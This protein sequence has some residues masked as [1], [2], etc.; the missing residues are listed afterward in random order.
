MK[1]LD[2]ANLLAGPARLNVLG[3]QYAAFMLRVNGLTAAGAAPTLAQFGLIRMT[4]DGRPC[5]SVSLATT[6]T[7]NAM[8]L[9]LV[10]SAIGAAGG[11]PITLS[12]MILSSRAGDGNIFDISSAD[13]ATVE[14]DLAAISAANV[15]SGTVEL[16]GIE[17]EGTQMYMPRLFT[18]QPNI[19]ASSLAD[20]QLNYENVSH[21]YVVTLTNLDRIQVVRDN[22]VYANGAVAALL[23]FSN[24]DSRIEAAFTAGLRINMHRSGALSESLSDTLKVEIFTTAGGVAT[25]E[26]VTVSLDFTPDK[27]NRSAALVEAKAKA[28]FERKQADNKGRPVTVAKALS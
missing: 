17:Q 14:L 7:I 19:A 1:R 28:K 10:E 21:L 25:P 27:L 16:Y 23:A 2:S 8:D 13:N 11:N 12:A 20:V 4:V 5:Y 9:G 6:Q 26:L 18:N 3:G 22:E 15:A 24:M